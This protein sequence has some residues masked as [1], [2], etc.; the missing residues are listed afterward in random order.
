MEGVQSL[1]PTRR[2]QACRTRGVHARIIAM[3]FRT[4]R[5]PSAGLEKIIALTFGQ[6][7]FALDVRL[8]VGTTHGLL[9]PPSALLVTL[10]F[11]LNCP[12][13]NGGTVGRCIDTIGIRACY[14][15]QTTSRHK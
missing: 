14:L 6:N 12:A 13:P 8:L 2:F 7:K 10:H 15:G 5:V 4:L 3:D 9:D 11:C 1:L